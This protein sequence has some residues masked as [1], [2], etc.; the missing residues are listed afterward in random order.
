MKYLTKK[1]KIITGIVLLVILA[2][3]FLYNADFLRNREV[4]NAQEVAELRKEENEDLT[5]LTSLH[6]NE[7]EVT[8]IVV[9][10]EGE[11]VELGKTLNF[12]AEVQGEGDFTREVLWEVVGEHHPDTGIGSTGTLIVSKEEKSLSLRV[13]A[14][15]VYDET[16]TGEK[17][18]HVKLSSEESVASLNQPKTTT[19]S[20]A[21]TTPKTTADLK[22]KAEALQKNITPEEKAKQREED[23]RI[24]EQAIQNSSKGE[25]DQYL[26]DPTPAGK[27]KPVEPGGE[28]NRDVTYHAT[29]SIR[30][31]TI[32]NNMDKFDRNKIDVLPVDGTIL[33]TTTVSFSPGESVYD[34]LQRVTRE[35]G[36]HMESVFTPIYNSAYVQGIHNL[37]EFDTGELSGWMYKVNGWFP[38]YGA[39]R[40]AL[41]DGDTIEWVYT[42]DLGRDVG[43][44]TMTQQ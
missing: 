2:A 27:P 41:Q 37:Y 36:I 17:T 22:K 19:T 30:C 34:V 43:D 28:I 29:L 32:L 9:T 18:V 35:K 3:S 4:V 11:V 31:D 33:S 8:G 42:C 26:T 20:V 24:K 13:Q 44:T 6:K 5:S 39:S 15:S 14:K 40:Y 10:S 12:S 7:G 38:N 23:L 21:N 16:K 25:K 1:Q